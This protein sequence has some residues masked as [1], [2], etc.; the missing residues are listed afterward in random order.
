MICDNIFVLLCRYEHVSISQRLNG[1][2]GHYVSV[3]MD[4]GYLCQ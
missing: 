2:F 3:V 4:M 1:S